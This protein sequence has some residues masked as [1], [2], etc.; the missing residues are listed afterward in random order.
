MKSSTRPITK[1][2]VDRLN[3]G[4]IA[5][6]A[7]VTGFGVRCQRRYKI[8]I[9]KYRIFG[10]PRW[11]SIGKHGA[12]WTVELARKEAKRLLG[13]VAAGI[14]PADARDMA[15]GDLTISELCDLYLKEGCTTKKPSTLA[16]DRGRIER[17]I[18]PILG[19][20]RVRQVSRGDVQRLLQDVADGRTATDQKTGFRGRAVVTG[21]KGVATKT[22]ALLSAIF[23]FAIDRGHCAE[24][25]AKGVK[26][27]KTKNSERF[28]SAE[29]LSRL[30]EALSKAEQEGANPFAI[31]AIRLLAL[32]G[33]RK[34]EI[35]ALHWHR[36]SNG[37]GYVDFDRACLH[38]LDS[39]TDEKRI[40]LGAPALDLL[41]NLPRIA[42]NPFV[43]PGNS[44]GHFV[45]LQKVWNQIRRR[46]GLEDV[47]LHDL[48]HSYAST[49][50][51]SGDS[52]YL[53]GKVLGHRQVSTTSRY[54]HLSD[55]PLRDVADRT[56]RQ[57]AGA[58]ETGAAAAKVVG[59][60]RGKGQK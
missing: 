13:Q 9:L 4:Q 5:W 54:A 56:A 21:G 50:V 12:P 45:G 38:L 18:K 53:V 32:T 59:L 34:S 60:F 33:A 6:D 26:T 37:A 55:D 20:R 14:D 15:K 19:H 52:L 11:I 57:I 25:P 35:L 47:R 49:A 43:F 30:G 24:N 8:F 16:T 41:A 27:F 28:L 31:A 48:R 46:A 23:N 7:D 39:K 22:V 40:P 17:H 1:A 3:P 58:M 2:I 36:N 29:E 10:R 51:A 42:G 44:G